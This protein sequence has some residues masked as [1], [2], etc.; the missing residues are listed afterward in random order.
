MSD[1]EPDLDDIESKAKAATLGPYRAGSVERYHVFTP[2]DAT[3]GPER[4]LLRVNEHFGNHERDAE[5]L[6]SLDPTT[7]LALVA[8]CRELRRLRAE[9]LEWKKLASSIV[10]AEEAGDVQFRDC[11]WSSEWSAEFLRLAR[12]AKEGT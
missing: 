9:L 8:E 1:Y 11:A 5:Y 3:M 7:A 12:G 4:V 2:H 10:A 6:A